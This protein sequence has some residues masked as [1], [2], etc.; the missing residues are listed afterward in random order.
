MSLLA[1]GPPQKQRKSTSYEDAYEDAS[2]DESLCWFCQQSRAVLRVQLPHPR[3]PKRRK[4]KRS[5]CLLHYYTT[6][7]ARTA[8]TASSSSSNLSSATTTT[9]ATAS[10]SGGS[11]QNAT[12]GDVEILDQGE[13]DIQLKPMQE[14]FAEAFVQLQQE[15]TEEAAKAFSVQQHDPLAILHNLNKKSRFQRTL[16]KPPL[17]SLSSSLSAKQMG[18]AHSGGFL[19]DVPL[20]ERLVRTHQKQAEIQRE[21]AQRMERASQQHEQ[22]QPQQRA[23]PATTKR[24]LLLNTQQPDFSK[25]RKSSRKSIWNTVM[26]EGNSNN[27]KV[28]DSSKHRSKDQTENEQHEQENQVSIDEEAANIVT[29]A[30]SCGSHQVHNMGLNASRNQDLKKGETWGVKDRGDEV[31]N[32]LQCQSCGKTWSEE[33]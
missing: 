22:P 12:N 24:S 4:I 6:P 20:P 21:M 27:N 8:K 28:T 23:P 7:A 16:K 30:C 13:F 25:R 17:P 33:A 10:G 18:D 26:E 15:I 9:A 14:I 19:R 29:S 5:Y 11:N 1:N 32:R 3:F 31:I 2:L